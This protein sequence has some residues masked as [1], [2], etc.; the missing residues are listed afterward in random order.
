[1]QILLTDAV[2]LTYDAVYAVAFGLCQAG[3]QGVQGRQPPIQV[4]FADLYLSVF[5]LVSSA[6]TDKQ[7]AEDTYGGENYYA[8]KLQTRNPVVERDPPGCVF[9]A[10]FHS[11]DT[12]VRSYI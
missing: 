2:N 3:A 9:P 8:D 5:Q 11:Q 4:G 7:D 1:M 10:V 12:K 6:I